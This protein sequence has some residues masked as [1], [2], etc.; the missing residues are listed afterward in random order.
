MLSI[1]G[2]RIRDWLIKNVKNAPAVSINE[3]RSRID[4]LG[5]R[6]F[7]PNDIRINKFIYLKIIHNS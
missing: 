7:L 6:L 1:Q 2:Q 4:A 3:A 5:K